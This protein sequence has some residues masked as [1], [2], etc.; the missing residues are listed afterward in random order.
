[1]LRTLTARRCI[2]TKSPFPR[3]ALLHVDRRAPNRSNR[4]AVAGAIGST[5]KCQDADCRREHRTRGVGDADSLH[6]AI[7]PGPVLQRIGLSCEVSAK[8]IDRRML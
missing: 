5:R 4:L 2:Y 6:I 1:M 7:S 8:N 3:I